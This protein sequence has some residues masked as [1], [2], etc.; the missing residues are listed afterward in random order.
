MVSNQNTNQTSV[1]L[2]RKNFKVVDLVSGR[3]SATYIFGI[4]GMSK[5]ALMESSKL[6]MY[7]KYN[8]VGKPG[9]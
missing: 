5:K 6:K 3:A 4:G 1:E 7:E 9:A 2:N 8:L